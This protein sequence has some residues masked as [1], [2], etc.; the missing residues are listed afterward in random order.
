MLTIRSAAAGLAM[1]ALGSQNSSFYDHYST[2][3]IDCQVAS[4]LLDGP[5]ADYFERTSSTSGISGKFGS[6]PGCTGKLHGKPGSNPGCTDK[7]GGNPRPIDKLGSNPPLSNF[8]CA[9]SL[10]TLYEMIL[11]LVPVDRGARGIEVQVAD[12]TRKRSGSFYTP[13]ALSKL[14]VDAALEPLLKEPMRP[15]RPGWHSNHGNE[16]L[17]KD[18]KLKKILQLRVLDPAMGAGI[19]L[20]AAYEHLLHVAADCI[21]ETRACSANQS[22]I[23]EDAARHV[24]QGSIRTDDVSRHIAQNCIYGVDIDEVA[25]EAARLALWLA[26]GDYKLSPRTAFPN[27]RAGNSLVGTCTESAGKYPSSAWKRRDLSNAKMGT[28]QIDRLDAATQ[29]QPVDAAIQRGQVDAATQRRRVSSPASERESLDEWCA[30]WFM[31]REELLAH[32]ASGVPEE[33]VRSYRG[34]IKFFHWKV[35]FPE[36]FASTNP[37]FDAVIGNPPWEIEKPNSREFFGS[38]KKEYWN[39]GKQDAIKTQEE[40]KERFPQLEAEW[41][42]IYRDHYA[43]ANWVKYAPE[44]FGSSSDSMG[45]E[46]SGSSSEHTSSSRRSAHSASK[47]HRAGSTQTRAFQYQGRGDANL[48]KLFV[49]QAYRLTKCGGT[50]GLIVPSGIYSDCGTRELRQLLLDRCD[51]RRIIGFDNSDGAFDIHRSFKYCIFVATKGGVT[52]QTD[53]SFMNTADSLSNAKIGLGSHEGGLNGGLD[54]LQRESLERISPKWSVICEVENKRCLE[55]VDKICC[56]GIRLGDCQFSGARLEFAREF[57]MTLD[58]RLFYARQKVELGGAI[59]DVYGNWLAGNWRDASVC[60]APQSILES[61]ETILSARGD[62]VLRLEEISNVFVPLYEGRMIGQFDFSEKQW[63]SGKGRQAVWRR[64]DSK[65]ILGP[66][67]L[68]ALETYRER[69]ATSFKTAFLAVGSPTNARTMISTCLSEAACGNS[70]PVFQVP[71]PV[72]MLCAQESPFESNEHNFSNPVE[73]HLILTSILN[74]FVFDFALRRRMSGN[75]LN[76]FVLEECTIPDI[77]NASESVLSILRTIARCATLLAMDGPRFSKQ[78][79]SLGCQFVPAPLDLTARTKLRASIDALVAV[80]YG[81]S[82]DEF[83]VILLGDDEAGATRQKGFWR[84]DKNLPKTHSLIATTIRSGER[85]FEIGAPAFCAELELFI[86][87]SVGRKKGPEAKIHSELLSK[88][89]RLC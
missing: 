1:Q 42:R 24:S 44:Q 75:N 10:C 21:E 79:V 78:L 54:V 20:L 13:S 2:L 82:M 53:A 43:M 46:H 12:K 50:V 26:V 11:N 87:G 55:L 89:L 64:S 17:L 88:I 14:T 30:Y 74:S 85:L 63:T 49:E 31:S 56:A 70:V 5:L 65:K 77:A 25:V 72:P 84:V 52:L 22:L 18:G 40:L 76:Y 41:L 81:L 66:Q 80:L 68:V 57:D 60:A 29:H 47:G 48:Y 86:E 19:F 33:I 16:S 73:F 9:E 8:E 15:G 67:Y 7:P 4:S 39:L 61:E 51:L 38:F 23:P 3:E 27:L 34:R 83:A 35:E 69:R 58:S 6:N 62:K 71:E 36:V 37:G 32:E 28:R 59:Q 45:S